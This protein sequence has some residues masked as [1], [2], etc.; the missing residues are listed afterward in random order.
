MKGEIKGQEKPGW[1]RDGRVCAGACEE[2]GGRNRCVDENRARQLVKERVSG[3]WGS[4]SGKGNVVGDRG[5]GQAQGQGKEKGL[6][7]PGAWERVSR[8]GAGVWPWGLSC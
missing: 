5:T 4:E 7:C 1:E 6:V 3:W 8:W 2:L